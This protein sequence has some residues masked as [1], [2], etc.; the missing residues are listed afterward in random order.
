MGEAPNL[1]VLPHVGQLELLAFWMSMNNREIVSR[2][3]IPGRGHRSAR[4]NH[5]SIL[6][7]LRQP[8]DIQWQEN[9]VQYQY[10]RQ[11]QHNGICDE[12]DVATNGDDAK[13]DHVLHAKCGQHQGGGDKSNCAAVRHDCAPCHGCAVDYGCGYDHAALSKRDNQW[14]KNDRWRFSSRSARTKRAS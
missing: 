11:V 10:G 4:L 3:A 7:L 2:F 1:G 12:R 5:P 8:P 13:V 9:E 14:S 6:Q